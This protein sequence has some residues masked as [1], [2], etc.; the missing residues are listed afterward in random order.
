MNIF[1]QSPKKK[2]MPRSVFAA[3]SNP[4]YPQ[5]WQDTCPRLLA[6]LTIWLCVT[7][8]LR[9]GYYGDCN[10]LLGPSSSRLFEANSVFVKQVEVT[11]TY[12]KGVIL[13][14]FSQKPELNVEESWN[15]SNIMIV[16]SYRRKGFSL[17]L[18]KGSR[19]QLGFEAEKSSL[20]QLEV[21]VTKGEDETL[22]PTNSP[23]ADLLKYS[24]ST[25]GKEAEYFI[26][27]DDRYYIGIINP[28]PR[29]IM[30]VMNTTVSSKMYDDTKAKSMC[31]STG[32]GSCRL[33]VLF[34]NTQYVVVTTP[35]NGNLDEWF[36]ELSFVARL[37]AYV[38]ILGVLVIIIFLM[39][40]FLGACNEEIDETEQPATSVATETEPLL[41]EKVIGLP[42]GTD[43]DDQESGTGSS[44]E[45]LYDGKICVIC[46]D[47]PRNCFFV[48]CGHCATCQDCANRIMEGENRVC[49]ICRRLVHKVR[50]LIIP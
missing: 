32:S 38:S 42:Y 50:K 37:A 20:N 31:S 25:E 33:D 4:H 30:V 1:L 26:E 24:T 45:D 6:P 29:S 47:M 11:D 21:S 22:L 16:G 13:Y 39:L 49:P 43:E 18:N 35:N 27:E 34:P 9:Y 3:A 2:K 8:S 23:T 46:Y 36:I 40:K 28:N 19:I 10:M 44:S 12:R 15:V 5:P 48:P 41:P 17:W 7:I 14:G